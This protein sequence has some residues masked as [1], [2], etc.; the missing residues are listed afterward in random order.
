[1][2]VHKDVLISIFEY[3]KDRVES[4]DDLTFEEYSDSIVVMLQYQL[5]R[6]QEILEAIVDKQELIRIYDLFLANHGLL[7]Q[8]DN[9]YRRIMERKF[10]AK[11]R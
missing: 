6:N 8:F 2:N 4:G 10:Q 3:Y 1:M 7:D 9:F 11:G 5:I